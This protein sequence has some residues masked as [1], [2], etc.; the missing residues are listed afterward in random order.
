[1]CA[2]ANV[3]V[4]HFRVYGDEWL[5]HHL[6][7]LAFS[8]TGLQSIHLPESLEV[9]CEICFADCISL[10]SVT[11]D[12]NSRLSRLESLAFYKSGLESIHLPGSLEVICESCFF[13]CKSLTSVT[14]DS[15]SRLQRIGNSAFAFTALTALVIPGC[16]SSFAG[17][18]LAGLQ[19]QTFS[20]SGISMT[21]C[22]CNYFVQAFS[23]RF[24][25]RYFG[26][27]VNVVVDS[28]VEV[29]CESCFS[30]CES[31][32]S[33]TFD[34]N[35]LLS[36]LESRAFCLSRLRSI[37]LPGSLEVICECCFHSCNSLTS[38]TFDAN[39]RLS[40]LESCAF[41]A[42]GLKSIHLPGSLEV[43]C[44]SCFSWHYGRRDKTRH[45]P[46][47]RRL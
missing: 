37:H 41:S 1:L 32:T 11:F 18:A 44:A 2:D 10:A 3:A 25:I 33:V 6:E 5:N 16:I 29:I 20:F 45:R 17:S 39:S 14:F 43:I 42:S 34:A 35:S 23:G 40:R 28:S 9:I 7:S 19:L 22:I 8:L 24:L 38:V 36:R 46:C 13:Y 27:D 15:I 47:D 4:N 31:L 21:Y 26:M 30:A 12:A